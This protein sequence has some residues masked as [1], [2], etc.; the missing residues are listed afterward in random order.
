MFDSIQ[1]QEIFHR[2][3]APQRQAATMAHQL[4]KR[5]EQLAVER[6][7]PQEQAME[8]LLRVLVHGRQGE[9]P[10]D[11]PKPLPPTG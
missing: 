5:A 8:H 6:K 4:I 2:L 10:P 7:I 9:L 1:I 11:F 3:G